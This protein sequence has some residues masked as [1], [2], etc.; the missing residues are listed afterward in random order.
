MPAP[1]GHS[2]YTDRLAEF[3]DLIAPA[4]TLGVPWSETFARRLGGRFGGRVFCE[5]GSADGQF[6]CDVAADHP[7]A[8]F[9]GVDW[10][11]KSVHAAAARAAAG[12]LRNV[13][14]IRGPGQDLPRWFQPAELAGIWVWHPDPID[15]GGRLIAEPFLS[16]IHPLLRPG[17]TVAIKTD[18]PGYFQ[19]IRSLLG[20]PAPSWFTDDPARIGPSPRLRRR[21]VEPPA[22]LPPFSPEVARRY[23]VTADVADFWADP[24][25]ARHTQSHPF[26]GRTTPFECRYRAKR[27]P[28]YY[29]ELTGRSAGGNPA[30]QLVGWT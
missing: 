17:G 23:R 4:G 9:V 20:R 22:T 1:P 21:D 29:V 25:A 18:H 24:A 16:S 2:R 26:A 3:A 15:R 11:F 28:I 14:L 6:L 30:G 5:V 12:G 13:A 8:G 19:S 10:K 7:D 27:L